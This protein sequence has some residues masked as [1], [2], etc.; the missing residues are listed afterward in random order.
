[1][2]DKDIQLGFGIRLRRFRESAGLSLG[3]LQAKLGDSLSRQAIHKYEKGE[4]MPGS[5]NLIQLCDALQ[6][7]PDDLLAASP[8][9]FQAVEFRR[10]AKFSAASQR[11]LRGSLEI[12]FE[13]LHALNEILGLRPKFKPPLH[14]VGLIAT[15]EDAERAAE[16][17]RKDWDLGHDAIPSL[18][19]LLEANGIHVHLEHLNQ[20]FFGASG[21]S[22]DIPIVVLNTHPDQ[23]DPV[24]QRFTAAHELGHLVL[25]LKTGLTVRMQEALCHRFAG[26]LLM[27]AATLKQEL[28][29][30]RRS[31]L[32]HYELVPLKERYGLSLAALYQRAEQ[33]GI[34]GQAQLKAWNIHRN[35]AGWR[36]S[37]PGDYQANETPTRFRQHILRA[38]AE[39][40]ISISKSA[41]LTNL[42]L[43]EIRR[44]LAPGKAIS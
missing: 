7:E 24:R 29:G 44:W 10:Q 17:L 40:T 37:E 22:G 15:P 25:P 30:D 14:G 13:R 36:K 35:R 18:V 33:V 19:G 4:A 20:P 41:A 8:R 32:A 2:R 31:K 27:P 34:I 11:R 6:V 26:A 3:D 39:E 9:E 12:A 23:T 21:H 5:T 16:R 1:M 28:G 38:L 43:S 42:P